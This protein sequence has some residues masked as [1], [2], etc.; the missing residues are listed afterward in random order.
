METL[1]WFGGGPK[2]MFNMVGKIQEK[3]FRLK[4]S[5]HYLNPAIA[6]PAARLVRYPCGERVI[7]LK[8]ESA[9]RRDPRGF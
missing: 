2:S 6:V 9:L 4:G 1:D 5:R 7:G 8:T 3:V